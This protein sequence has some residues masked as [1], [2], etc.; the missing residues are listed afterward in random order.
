MLSSTPI[1]H[2]WAM[3]EPNK[4]NIRKW[5]TALRSGQFK[6]GKSHLKYDTDYSREGDARHCCLGVAC[7]LAIAN[8]VEMETSRRF[9]GQ[10]IFGG[11]S[12]TL[13]NEVTDWLGITDANPFVNVPPEYVP[14]GFVGVPQ[15]RL[16]LLNDSGV[17]FERIATFIE[18]TY[19]NA[20]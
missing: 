17:E 11:T 12:K 7:D 15:E 6:Q 4:E 2:L 20:E 14:P 18:E 5:V 8:G 3:M 16:A 10:Y 19:L 1:S 13:P 9:N